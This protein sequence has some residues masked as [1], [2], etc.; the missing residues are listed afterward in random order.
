VDVTLCTAAQG[1]F[2]FPADR[3]VVAF[4]KRVETAIAS[5]ETEFKFEGLSRYWIALLAG[6]ISQARELTRLYSQT[7]RAAERDITRDNVLETLFKPLNEFRSKMAERYIQSRLAMSYADFT[8]YRER[9][10]SDDLLR[11]LHYDVSNQ[12]TDVELILI[13]Y[14]E[15]AFHL[16]KVY[17]WDVG[18]HEPFAAI[19]KGTDIA[20]VGMHQRQID[21]F[22]DIGKALYAVYEAQKQGEN[23]PGVG[24][25][26]FF[27]VLSPP[28]GD[29]SIEPLMV[30]RETLSV[31]SQHYTTYGPKELP[32]T[33]PLPDR[34]IMTRA[35]WTASVNRQIEE[36]ERAGHPVS[37]RIRRLLAVASPPLPPQPK[38]SRGRKRPRKG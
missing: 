4:D 29:A 2:R 5:S 36:R 7:L 10:P 13:G 17:G 9:L 25:E 6:P 14:Y 11:Q 12:A 16:F 24:K 19:G 31:L 8:Q 23:A 21:E 20:D 18:L 30:T 27:G 15:G 26:H 32:D 34:S 37:P 35:E 3:V 22:T 1:F 33:M 28:E 38:P